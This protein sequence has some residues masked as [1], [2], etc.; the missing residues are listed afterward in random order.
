MNLIQPEIK[1][2]RVGNGGIIVNLHIRINNNI[3][4]LVFLSELV[5][6]CVI[7]LFK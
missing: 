2:Q 6:R 4:Q 3:S 7:A 5:G 1:R